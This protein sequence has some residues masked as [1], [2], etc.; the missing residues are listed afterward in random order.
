MNTFGGSEDRALP[1][2]SVAGPAG[3]VRFAEVR[4]G[5]NLLRG[6]DLNDDAF[7]QM[8]GFN[9][10]LH[11]H[12]TEEAKRIFGGLAEGGTFATPLA[13]ADWARLFGMVTDRF[14]VPW[15]ILAPDE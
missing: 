1:S 3:N 2:G 11:V 14:G 7:V 6:N 13:E 4:F 5:D 9:V 15:L 10:S 8:S 12:S